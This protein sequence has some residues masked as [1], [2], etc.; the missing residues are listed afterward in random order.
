MMAPFLL[1]SESKESW[2]EEVK[3]VG[4]IVRRLAMQYADVF[5][6]LDRYLE[7]ALKT[8]PM[9]QYYSGDGVHPNQQGAEFIGQLYCGAV[10]PLI[11][12]LHPING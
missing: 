10:S 8:Q 12:E 6:P 9:P 2:R 1:D 11:Q 7:D 5:I 4:E 3:R